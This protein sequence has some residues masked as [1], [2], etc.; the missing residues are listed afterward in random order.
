M[1]LGRID[2]LGAGPQG[3]VATR[4]NAQIQGGLPETRILGCPHQGALRDRLRSAIKG[5]GFKYPSCR[6]TLTLRRRIAPGKEH[7]L[8]AALAILI[9]TGQARAST[10]EPYRWLG[11]IATGWWH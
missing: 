10:L 5:A 6:V 1:S 7:L 11:T 4:V 9:A 3:F 2:T 8:P